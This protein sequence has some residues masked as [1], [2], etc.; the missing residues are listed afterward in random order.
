MS[1]EH[2][3]PASWGQCV[4]F[5]IFHA[6]CKAW[7]RTGSE[8]LTDHDDQDDKH[9]SGLPRRGA[10]ELPMGRALSWGP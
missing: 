4:P 5:C 10:L 7:C 8:Q 6:K 2:T 1:L 3:Q 9:C